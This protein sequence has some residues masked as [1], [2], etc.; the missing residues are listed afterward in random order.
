MQELENLENIRQIPS[1]E[2]AEQYL[3]GGLL[4]SNQDWDLI[5]TI[6]ESRDFFYKNNRLIFEAISAFA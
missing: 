4:I 3:I 6:V 2:I 5:A 1:D